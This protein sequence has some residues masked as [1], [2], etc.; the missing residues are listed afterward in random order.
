MIVNVVNQK[1]SLCSYKLSDQREILPRKWFADLNLTL[2]KW[3]SS[4]LLTE[5]GMQ[6]N[7]HINR[8]R[9]KHEIVQSLVI[10][11][12]K[13]FNQKGF[14]LVIFLAT[15]PA[16]PSIIPITVNIPPTMAIRDVAY[17]YHC[18]FRVR[19]LM[20]T[21]DKSYWNLA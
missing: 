18:R 11:N 12:K 13:M 17:S 20:D 6:L 3:T 9:M 8:I 21:G 19:K 5:S 14:F 16:V 10:E 4:K 2:L 7:L 15:V 1:S